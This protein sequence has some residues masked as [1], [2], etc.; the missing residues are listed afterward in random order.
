[1]SLT[2]WGRTICNFASKCSINNLDFFREKQ[3]TYK[4]MLCKL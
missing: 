3:K 1:M 4:L 2:E